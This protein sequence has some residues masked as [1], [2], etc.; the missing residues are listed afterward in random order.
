[1]KKYKPTTPGQRGTVIPSYRKSLTASRPL[2]RL[3]RGKAKR[4]G[5]DNSGRITTRN[6]GGGNKRRYRAIDFQYDKR[7]IPAYIKTVEYDPN[8]SAFIARVCYADGEW[9]YVVA[10]AGM[11]EGDSF[12]VSEKAPVETGNRTMLA[13][14]PVGTLVHNIEFLPGGGARLARSAG[15]YGEVIAHADKYTHIKMQSGEVRKIPAQ[16]WASVGQVS[17]E[18]HKLRNFGKAGRSRWRGIRPTVRGSAMAV[19]D[20]PHGGGEGRSGIGL[21]RTKN[22]YGKAVQG[23]KTRKSKKYSNSLIVRRRKNARERRR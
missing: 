8:R 4:G 17:N 9:R 3:T 6:K 7:D 15:S 12:I 11:K 21:R 22:I 10:P 19:H 13:S 20:H 18:E 16:S 5:R 14:I 1:M 23:I 2:K